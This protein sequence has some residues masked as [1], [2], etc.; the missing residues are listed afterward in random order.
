VERR[1]RSID[2]GLDALQA[3]MADAP[4]DPD[5]LLEHILEHVVGTDE[6]GDD[7]AMLAARLLPVAP[8]PLDLRLAADLPSMD[9][10]RDAMRTWLRG[11]DHLE[12]AD[13]EDV[14]L[15]TWEACANAIEHAVEPAERVVVVRA[16]LEDSRLQVTVADT[17]HWAPPSEREDRGLGLRLMESLV[18][19]VDIAESDAGTTVTLEKALS[20]SAG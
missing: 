8:R 4:K 11:V 19:S 18:S 16:R 3:A 7:I 9:L 6:R 1:G 5:R 14:V 10:V 12:R 17:G 2:E 13:V 20:A 15:A